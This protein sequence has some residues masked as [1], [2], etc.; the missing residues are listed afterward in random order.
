MVLI[1]IIFHLVALACS[2]HVSLTLTN[3]STTIR[4][5]NAMKRIVGSELVGFEHGEAQTD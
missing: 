1:L 3:W 4:N 5:G 2:N